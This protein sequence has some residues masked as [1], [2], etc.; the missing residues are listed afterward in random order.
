MSVRVSVRM[1]DMGVWQLLA[2]W[3]FSLFVFNIL[4]INI[5]LFI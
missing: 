4:H 3:P 5:S 2:E 1:D